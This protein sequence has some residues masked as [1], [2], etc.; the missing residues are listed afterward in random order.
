[1]LP[2]LTHPALLI[3][4][5]PFFHNI[6]WTGSRMDISEGC[7]PFTYAIIIFFT[8]RVRIIRWQNKSLKKLC[9]VETKRKDSMLDCDATRDIV[10]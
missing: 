7:N 3:D 10:V 2:L 8:Q 5:S 6:Y 1:M 4:I 9:M